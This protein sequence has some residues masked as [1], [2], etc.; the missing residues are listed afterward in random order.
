MYE[1]QRLHM[2]CT[3]PA[4]CEVS[5][6]QTPDIPELR[7]QE[8]IEQEIHSP[9]S[10]ENID[11]TCQRKK[12]KTVSIWCQMPLVLFLRQNWHLR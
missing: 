5:M 8:K 3:I 4:A 6:L 11:G 10:G 1:D 9:G 7:E 12:G 2:Q